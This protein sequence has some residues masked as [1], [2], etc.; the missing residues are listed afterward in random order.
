MYS[1][2]I[3]SYERFYGPLGI[4][5]SDVGLTYITILAGSTGLF[6]TFILYYVLVYGLVFLILVAVHTIRR[7]KVSWIRYRGPIRNAMF[8][9]LC[10]VLLSAGLILPLQ[11]TLA[12]QKVQ[13]GYAVYKPTLIPSWYF[14]FPLTVL[15]I[16]ADYASIEP[17][18]SSA[19]AAIGAI[20][21][22]PL[23]YL[24]QAN[25][26]VVVYD[27]VAQQALYLP[28]ASIVLTIRSCT[29]QFPCIAAGAEYHVT[30]SEKSKSTQP[31]DRIESIRA[32][33]YG[34]PYTFSMSEMV[35]YIKKGFYFYTLTGREVEDLILARHKGHEYAK[36]AL[37]REQ[38]PDAL[39]Q[40]P[41]C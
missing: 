11:A 10:L 35:S 40:L 19:G 3:V 31:Y 23:L 24:G 22:R 6:L 27:V 4:S 41:D 12:A 28:A 18:S 9:L 5:P 21:T 14:E 29:K 37:D 1:I 8:G 34:R 32:G 7:R 16:H 13:E 17:S 30:C 33:S 15:S 2:L 39:L 38:Q 25:S 26:T 36:G 20:R